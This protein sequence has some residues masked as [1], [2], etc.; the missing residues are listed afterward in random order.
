MQ[1]KAVIVMIIKNLV[2]M[3]LT[4]KMIFWALEIAAAQTKTAIDDNVVGI[5][6]AGYNSDNEALKL[7]LE[8]L[9]SDL[10]AKTAKA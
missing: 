10:N 1:F 3:L 7:H 9:L 5:V 6:K 8:S 4:K 2:A